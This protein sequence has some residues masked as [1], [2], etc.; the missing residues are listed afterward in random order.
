MLAHSYSY[1]QGSVKSILVMVCVYTGVWYKN[2][3]YSLIDFASSFYEFYVLLSLQLMSIY[4]E[5]TTSVS[6]AS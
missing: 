2:T 1:S 4:Y 6:G 3:I 5:F